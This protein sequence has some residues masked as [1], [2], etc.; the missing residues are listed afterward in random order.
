MT[1]PTNP[2]LTPA[3]IEILVDALNFT[4]SVVE[5]ITELL[6]FA[7]YV[8]GGISLAA[9]VVGESLEIFNDLCGG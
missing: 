1:A 7:P 3:E 6:P 8:L 9:E 4:T 2:N 5:G